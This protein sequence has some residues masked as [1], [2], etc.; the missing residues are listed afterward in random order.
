MFVSIDNIPDIIRQA[1]ISA[2]DKNFYRN[3]GLDLISILSAF[4]YNVSEYFRRGNTKFRGGST[5]TQQVVK[6]M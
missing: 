1:F 4:S 5:I 3:S 6:N 2:E